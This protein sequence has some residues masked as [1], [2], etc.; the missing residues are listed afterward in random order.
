MTGSCVPSMW[1]SSDI[2]DGLD[3]F[4]NFLSSISNW[5]F[6]SLLLIYGYLIQSLTVL[7]L[8]IAQQV[9]QA[10]ARF[11]SKVSLQHIQRLDAVYPK[12][13]KAFA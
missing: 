13:A 8:D 6:N 10:A 11:V 12:T 1:R 9:S 2:E 7:S 3:I 4:G 5:I